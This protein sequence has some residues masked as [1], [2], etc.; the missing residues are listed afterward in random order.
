MKKVLVI[1]LIICGLISC[2]TPTK[3]FVKSESELLQIDFE[4]NMLNYLPLLDYDLKNSVVLD[5]TYKLLVLRNYTK[6]EKYLSSVKSETQD[7]YLAKTLYYV[8][9]VEYKEA[10][11]YLI[12]INEEQYPMLRELL[13]IDLS[14]ELS[15]S[16]N[17]TNYKQ[18]LQEYQALIDKYPVNEYLKKIV[19]LRTRYIRYNY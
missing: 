6:L 15:K 5:S 16:I 9:I 1:I 3:Y 7:F 14:Y 10:A 18:Y 11:K 13:F 4:R 2:S 17:S 8:S 19:A 12:K